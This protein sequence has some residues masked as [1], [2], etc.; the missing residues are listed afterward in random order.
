M[1]SLSTFAI[2]LMLLGMAAHADFVT[3]EEAYEVPLNSFRMPGTT[4]G[5]LAI[6]TCDECDIQ[7]IRVT[8]QTQYVFRNEHLT[9][10]EFRKALGGVNQR[11]K[12]WIIVLHHLES[13]TVSRV[14][15]NF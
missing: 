10:A 2:G 15:L 14:T 1:K 9:L 7:T 13:D 5:A 8:G 6:K 12:K 4:A 11:D 3:V